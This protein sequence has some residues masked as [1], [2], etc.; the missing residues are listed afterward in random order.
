MSVPFPFACL[1]LPLSTLV[2]A[3]HAHDFLVVW[4]PPS[5]IRTI[6]S[7]RFC[8]SLVLLLIPVFWNNV[9]DFVTLSESYCHVYIP[10]S[11]T[12]Y[13]FSQTE[14]TFC[15]Q[16]KRMLCEST[17]VRIPFCYTTHHDF[18][19]RFVSRT[20]SVADCWRFVPDMLLLFFVVALVVWHFFRDLAGAF[21][22]VLTVLRWIPPSAFNLVGGWS[23]VTEW[24]RPTCCDMMLGLWV[25]GCFF[26]CLRPW[27]VGR[28]F[29]TLSLSCFNYWYVQ[30][31]LVSMQLEYSKYLALKLP[32][33][34]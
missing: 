23:I 26:V 27:L 17:E 12:F 11:L 18:C 8:I 3:N 22:L 14:P 24:W 2:V 10:F 13:P 30:S 9:S 29:S 21:S 28:W 4:F 19:H 33:L 7:C 25:V 32:F 20:T 15:Y 31:T 1:L 34:K 5:F 6:S 16:S